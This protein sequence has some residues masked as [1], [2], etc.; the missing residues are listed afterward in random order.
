MKVRLTHGKSAIIDA[1]DAKLIMGPKWHAV[2][3]KKNGRWYAEATLHSP[4]HTVRMARLIMGEPDCHVDHK[5][6]DTLDNRRSNLRAA[7]CSQ[8]NANRGAQRNNTS[9]YKGVSWFE[10]Y[11]CWRATITVRGQW[12]HLGYFVSKIA[13][14]A[15]YKKAAQSAFGEFARV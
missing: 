15:V 11:K 6:T 14:F 12:R 3:D 4:R 8:N 9:G 5:N 10:K 1:M 2:R 7:T 13:A